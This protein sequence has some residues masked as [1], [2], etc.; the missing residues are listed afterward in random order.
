MHRDARVDVRGERGAEHVH[1]EVAV[2]PLLDVGDGGVGGAAH[3]QGVHGRQERREPHVAGDLAAA[4]QPRQVAVGAGDEPVDAHPEEDA[5]LEGRPVLTR[6]L[7]AHP[8]SLARRHDVVPGS[9]GWSRAR[10]DRYAAT[11][12]PS[13]RTSPGGRP[14]WASPWR[15]ACCACTDGRSARDTAPWTAA[16]QTGSSTSSSACSWT[17]GRSRCSRC[18]SRTGW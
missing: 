13:R 4:L 9:G 6:Q 12:A 14:C 3:H 8:G 15:T 5:A 11:S 2:R 7:V 10:G 16:R 17:T 1:R 18:C